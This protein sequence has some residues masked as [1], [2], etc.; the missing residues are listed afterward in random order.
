MLC[1][2]EKRIPGTSIRVAGKI[3]IRIPESSRYQKLGVVEDLGVLY[4]SITL[5]INPEIWGTGL[6]IKTIE[7][8][9]YGCPVV[10]TSAGIQGIEEA[11]NRGILVGR[12]PAEI[13]IEC[14]ERLLTLPSFW[15]EQRRLA[16]DFMMDYLH[17]NQQR[18]SDFLVGH[19]P[20]LRRVHEVALHAEK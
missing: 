18:L 19:K 6:K 15:E 1:L 8:L 17:Q 3:C 7:P 5:A 16:Q 11:E 20:S 2:I 13:V 14:I 4:G 10:T 9:A 12:T